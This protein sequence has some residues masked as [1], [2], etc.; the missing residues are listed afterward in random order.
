MPERL[1]VIVRAYGVRDAV[2]DMRGLPPHLRRKVIRQ[3]QWEYANYLRRIIRTTDFGFTDRTGRLRPSIRVAVRKSGSN[4]R[5]R[6]HIRI[7]SNVR[8]AGYVEYNYGGRYSYARRA[9]RG[10][11]HVFERILIRRAR[12]ER[13]KLDNRRRIRRLATGRG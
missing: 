10:S 6:T 11:R 13:V 9:V 3:T 8:Y 4:Q 5:F 1:E 2:G 7:A 12:A